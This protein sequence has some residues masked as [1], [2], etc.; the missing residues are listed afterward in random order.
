MSEDSS[1]GYGYYY[2]NFNYEYGSASSSGSAS[3]LAGY[4]SSNSFADGSTED[5]HFLY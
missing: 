5:Y 1:Y 2:S 4:A 3:A